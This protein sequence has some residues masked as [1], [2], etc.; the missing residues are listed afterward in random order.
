[1][2]GTEEETVFF[3][4][5]LNKIREILIAEKIWEYIYDKEDVI[6]LTIS[7]RVIFWWKILWDWKGSIPI[8]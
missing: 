8:F 4:P 2:F 5:Q 6:L 1:M 3:L 7:I